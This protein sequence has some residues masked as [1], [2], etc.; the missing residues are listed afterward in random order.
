MKGKLVTTKRD[1]CEINSND[2]YYYTTH[3]AH[4]LEHANLSNFL[5]IDSR[6]IMMPY[7]IVFANNRK[8]SSLL[9]L[10]NLEKISASL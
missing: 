7:Q 8:V 6:Q 2:R 9:L 1:Y 5:L 10:S 4:Y 3:V